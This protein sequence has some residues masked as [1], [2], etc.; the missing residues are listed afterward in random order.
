MF[1]LVPLIFSL[2]IR[3]IQRFV[4]RYFIKSENNRIASPLQGSQSE[5]ARADSAVFQTLLHC[6]SSK[7]PWQ[8]RYLG[9]SVG[10]LVLEITIIRAPQAMA[11]RQKSLLITFYD[12]L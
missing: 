2:V 4:P 11:S 12:S 3:S 5:A 9:L 7:G 1:N 6:L 10:D 8:S